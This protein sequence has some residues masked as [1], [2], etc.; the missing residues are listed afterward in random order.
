[1]GHAKEEFELMNFD[2]GPTAPVLLRLKSRDGSLYDIRMVGPY[3]ATMKDAV[4]SLTSSHFN[5]QNSV[6]L[7]AIGL[8]MILEIEVQVCSDPVTCLR[9]M[10]NPELRWPI[11]NHAKGILI[12]GD[13]E[14]W[15]MKGEDAVY[16]GNLRATH[17]TLTRELDL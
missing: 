16:G 5:R 7:K 17:V 4:G 11:W 6:L 10:T 13:G 1:M 14:K 15:E 2:L 9:F 8:K 12:N 3:Y